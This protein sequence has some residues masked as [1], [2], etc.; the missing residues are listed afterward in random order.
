MKSG[1]LFTA[2]F[3]LTAVITP[4]LAEPKVVSKKGHKVMYISDVHPGNEDLLPEVEQMAKQFGTY[5]QLADS[6]SI[7]QGFVWVGTIITKDADAC[8]EST[9]EIERVIEK[10]VKTGK[11]V[12]RVGKPV[13]KITNKPIVCPA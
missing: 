9:H 7:N 4:A 6:I 12:S 8:T 10:E 3:C 13:M 2:A 11:I 1:F 5:D